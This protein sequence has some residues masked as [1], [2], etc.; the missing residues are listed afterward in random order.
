MVSLIQILTAFLCIVAAAFYDYWRFNSY[1]RV[2]RTVYRVEQFLVFS[3]CCGAAILVNYKLYG[4][5]DNLKVGLI[6]F[7][8][9][10]TWWADFLYYLF[11]EFLDWYAVFEVGT[12]LSNLHLDG[13][14]DLW[15]TPLGLFNWVISH[16]DGSISGWKGNVYPFQGIM[17]Q[18]ILGL[19][20]I[21]L[22]LI[23]L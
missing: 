15:W 22:I 18:L 13:T 2:N 4:P 6:F 11:A 8:F 19:I 21:I 1:G 10:W 14:T 3:L 12:P 17:L 16:L 5:H 9:W 23:Y 20:S 7:M